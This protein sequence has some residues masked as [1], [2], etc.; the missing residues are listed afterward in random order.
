VCCAAQI[1]PGNRSQMAALASRGLT[2]L[3][4]TSY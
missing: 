4:T 1:A 2:T 3:A